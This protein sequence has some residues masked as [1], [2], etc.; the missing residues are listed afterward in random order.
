MAK[1]KE[2][3]PLGQFNGLATYLNR[4][5]LAVDE[6]GAILADNAG[7]VTS[8]RRIYQPAV[9]PRAGFTL[10]YCFWSRR[11][12]WRW[13]LPSR[14]RST[15][16]RGLLKGPAIFFSI[17]PMIITPLVGS[18]ILYWMFNPAGILGATLQ[19]MT[20]TIRRCRC[21]L[22]G[23]DLDGAALLRRLDQ[24]DPSPSSCSM[25]ACRPCRHDTLESAR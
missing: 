2:E 18:L 4:N 3:Q 6:I 13:A 17:L 24:R 9:L 15:P 20:S 12:P 7:P 16:C 11:W 23:A 1:L 19:S 21:G 14:W 8:F 22:A 5:H 25:P 10:V